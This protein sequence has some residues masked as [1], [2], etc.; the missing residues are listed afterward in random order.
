MTT[1]ELGNAPLFETFPDRARALPRET[2]RRETLLAEVIWE[3]RALFIPLPPSLRVS[4]C[5]L[6]KSPVGSL[7]PANLE[8]A[9]SPC[10]FLTERGFYRARRCPVGAEGVTSFSL[11]QRKNM[12]LPA[13]VSEDQ[14]PSARGLFACRGF[15]RRGRRARSGERCGGGLRGARKSRFSLFRQKNLGGGGGELRLTG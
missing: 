1:C 8:T 10:R 13:E 11:P 14:A 15:V 6:A 12:V 2:Q 9:H 4:R 3:A 5:M 7:R